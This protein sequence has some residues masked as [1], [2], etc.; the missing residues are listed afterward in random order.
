LAANWL[1]QT[2]SYVF[3]NAKYEFPHKK[4]VTA[5]LGDV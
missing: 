2:A 3:C 5:I 1:S 4:G